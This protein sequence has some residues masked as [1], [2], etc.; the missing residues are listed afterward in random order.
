VRGSRWCAHRV[1]GRRETSGIWP[2]AEVQGG[3]RSALFLD[4]GGV[5]AHLRQ[6]H[7]ARWLRGGMRKLVAGLASPG[8]QRIRRI[9]GE[10]S[11][12]VL[13]SAQLRVAI[14]LA[15]EGEVTALAGRRD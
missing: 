3:R 15:G 9:D 10:E 5:P 8:E 13:S 6:R 12:A 2:A 14:R 11:A 1:Q 4:G 7:E